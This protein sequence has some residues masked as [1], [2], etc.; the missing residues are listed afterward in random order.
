MSDLRGAE[1]RQP[2]A[3]TCGSHM[4]VI[5]KADRRS[6]RQRVIATVLGTWLITACSSGSAPTSNAT[7]DPKLTLIEQKVFQ[8]SCTFSSCHGTDTPQQGLS[9]AGSTYHVLVNQHSSE[10]PALML[11]VPADPNGSFLLEKISIDHPASGSR[12]PY[13]SIPL[14]EGEVAAVR[15]W[16]EQGAQDD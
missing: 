12:M 9:L 6:C 15:Q 4:L 8:P 10:V 7:I 14:P 3:S 1:L 11:V 2:D 16:I 13:L 5:P